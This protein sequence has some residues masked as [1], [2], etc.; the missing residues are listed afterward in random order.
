[1]ENAVITN[2]LIGILIALLTYFAKRIVEKIDCIEKKMQ[3]VL[4]KDMEKSKDI[5]QLRHDVDSHEIRINN[6][7]NKM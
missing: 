5:Q 2:Y 3:D 6:L 7:E 4:I 1:M